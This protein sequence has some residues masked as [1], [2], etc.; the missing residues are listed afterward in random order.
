MTR[1]VD[2]YILVNI[3]YTHIHRSKTVLQKSHFHLTKV[4]VPLGSVGLNSASTVGG[5]ACD[6]VACDLGCDEDAID[7][8]ALA[9]ALGSGALPLAIP[10][11]T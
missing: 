5:V 7:A 1:V 3:Y 10:A 8:G 4:I 2:V 6:L 9:T 11:L